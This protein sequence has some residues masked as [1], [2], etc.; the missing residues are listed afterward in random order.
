MRGMNKL[1]RDKRSQIIAMLCEGNSMSATA[2]LAD[3]SF[4]T[5]SKLLIEAG[6]ACSE[7][8]DRAL[9]NLPCKRLQLDEIWAFIGAKEKNVPRD[10]K[11]LGRGDAWLWCAIDADTKLVPS[12]AVG[13]R[14]TD[15]ARA[16]VDDLAARLTS[17]VQI[18]TDGHRP[19]LQAIEGAFGADV[20]YAMLEKVYANPVEGQKRYSP[21]DCVGIKKREIAG[22]PDERHISTSF[23][24]RQNLT[25]RMSNRRYT[26]LT[27]AFS[28][29]LANHE[30]MVSLHYMHYNFCRIHKS[31]RTT[32]AQAAGVTQN[33]WAITDIV[34]V[35]DAWYAEQTK[36]RR[37]TQE[38]TNERLSKK[39]A[40]NF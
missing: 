4:N 3:V 27:N 24:E 34:D 22:Q 15:T 33:L 30:F 12:W 25:L 40:V 9:R 20:D 21:A 5:V 26:R 29:K 31:L 11:G 1:T 23:V 6:Q 28:K 32:P 36:A 7:Y 16:F 2:R 37:A 35:V 13:D 38:W 14:S 17:R 10:Q 8:Q 19:Y 39:D 18:T